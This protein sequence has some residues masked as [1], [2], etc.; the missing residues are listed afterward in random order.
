MMRC[1]ICLR[2]RLS[3][4]RANELSRQKE[5]DLETAAALAPLLTFIGGA[6]YHLLGE[7]SHGPSE[8]YT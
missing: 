8:F 7:A 6:R 3:P 5:H 1:M 4:L 2:G